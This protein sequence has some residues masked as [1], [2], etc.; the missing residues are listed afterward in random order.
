MT[1]IRK[2]VNE[3]TDEELGK[4]ISEYSYNHDFCKV[5]PYEKEDFC[6]EDQSFSCRDIVLA[7]A[8]KE[9]KNES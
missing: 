3:T 7:Y 5:C 8:L 2:W 9:A 6:R 1:N 4:I